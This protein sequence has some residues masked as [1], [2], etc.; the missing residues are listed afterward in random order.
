M[1]DR[2][3]LGD[4]FKPAPPDRTAD[5]AGLLPPRADEPESPPTHHEGVASV[6]AGGAAR[7]VE[8]AQTKPAPRH[9]SRGGRSSSSSGRQAG[10]ARSAAVPAE[11]NRVVPVVLDASILSDL[12]T[13]AART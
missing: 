2:P 7:Q 10:A 13:F 11:Q 4:M 6:D 9:R 3:K 5:L 8:A 12:R 1:A